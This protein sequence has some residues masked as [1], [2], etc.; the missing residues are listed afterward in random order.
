MA[1]LTLKALPGRARSLVLIAPAPDF[2]DKLMWPGLPDEAKAA[3][4]TTGSWMRPSAYGDGDYPL[5]K[6]LFEAG[7]RV[8]VLDGGP[9]PFA[10]KVRILQGTADP[11]VPW[12]HAVRTLEAIDS[13]DARLTLIRGGDHRLSTP[14]MIDLLLKTCAEAAA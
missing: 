4:E 10:G 2:T 6:A 9:I 14:A 3:I 7:K 11:D 5:T 8:C 12:R 13:P 1:L